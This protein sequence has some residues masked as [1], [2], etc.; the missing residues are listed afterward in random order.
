MAKIV[1]II[2]AGGAGTRLWPLSREAL[3]KQFL[4]LMG[5]DSLLQ[6]TLER[7]SS[8]AR[9]VIVCSE[10]HRFLVAE[11]LRERG[12]TPAAI[13]LE[14]VS[15]NTAPAIALAAL[16]CA[17]DD[18][19]LVLPADHFMQ[20]V[21]LFQ[22]ALA[23]AL[24][25]AQ[26][27]KLVTF[28]I[29]P[30]APMTGYGY[31]QSE[32]CGPEG[33]PV[34]AFKEKPTLECAEA[35]LHSGDYVWNSGMFV[36]R[37]QTLCDALAQFQPQMLAAVRHAW[38][39]A[40]HDLDFIRLDAE[41]F[42]QVPAQSIDYALME[43]TREAWMVPLAC[44]WSDVGSFQALADVLPQDERGNVQVGDVLA[45]GCRNAVLIGQN[46]L[47]VAQGVQD[48]LVVAV[49]DAVLVAPRDTS[50][51]IKPLV[52]QLKQHQREEAITSPVCYR[53]WGAYEVLDEGARYKVKRL[54][55]NPGQSLSRQLHHHRAEHWVVV[56]GTARIEV[57]GQIRLLTENE[58]VYIPV[59]AIHRLENPGKVVLEIVEVQ[60]G[61]YLG[62]DDIVRLEDSYQRLD[63]ASVDE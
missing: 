34:L 33:A 8:C 15:R 61:Q 49:G 56:K 40:H 22:A 21:D 37:A 57:E 55:V 41:R 27:G 54:S 16:A 24:N 35:F 36:F 39:S 45:E 23:H 60:S 6:S 62:E 29:T 25:A 48:L 20:E 30:T 7:V 43:H 26:Q 28:G 9:P 58:S 12:I 50:E 13:V 32:P 44:R 11:Q 51:A 63:R 52:E 59:G 14:P 5:E 31:I 46:Q 42:A 38:A 4:R 1:P 19:L 3:P 53:P 17:P 47:L 10:A 18:L 2:L